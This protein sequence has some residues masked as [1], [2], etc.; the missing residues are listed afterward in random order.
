MPA[1]IGG[2]GSAGLAIETT[3]NTYVAP[4]KSFPFISESIVRQDSLVQRRPIRQ[5][6]DVVGILGG[7]I[8]VTGDITFEVLPD[9]LIYFLRAARMTLVKT[10]GSSPYTYTFTPSQVGQPA[11]TL[12]ITIVRNGVVFGYVGCAVSQM[13]I[14]VDAST[15]QMMATA[16]IIGSEETDQSLPTPTY[17][18]TPAVIGAGMYSVQV[19]TATQVFDMDTFTFTVNDNGSAAYR[20]NNTSRGAQ[21]LQYGERETT[22]TMERDFI[23]KS[24]YGLFKALTAQSITVQAQKDANDSVTIT[25]PVATQTEYP[26]N[27]ASQGDL[28]RVATNFIASI[29]ST[30]NTYTIVVVTPENM[31]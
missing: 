14:T 10:G 3:P 28:L 4:T 22:M 18:A 30:G 20:L 6:A 11:K 13:V 24:Q 29:D 12:S 26:I 7:N 17:S 15:G 1:G 25:I 19:P 23:D 5:T 8:V 9:V 21:F 27:S 16:S 2:S 31:T